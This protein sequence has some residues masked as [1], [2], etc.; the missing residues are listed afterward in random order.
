[1]P[2]IKIYRF[3]LDIAHLPYL[4]PKDDASFIGTVIRGPTAL[5]APVFEQRT[6]YGEL[7]PLMLPY[8]EDDLLIRHISMSFEREL[9]ELLRLGRARNCL[10][11]GILGAEVAK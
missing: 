5:R 7:C 11:F 8:P 1:M 4:L 9:K 10:T 2:K 6:S 3:F